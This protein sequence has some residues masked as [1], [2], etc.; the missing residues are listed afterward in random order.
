MKDKR[1]NVGDKVTYKNME[2]CGTHGYYRFWGEN[3]HNDVGEIVGYIRYDDTH[4]CWIICV[5]CDKHRLHMLECEFMEYGKQLTTSELF[6]I[7]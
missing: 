4:N 5:V 2:D 1:F 3:K 6:P 7:Y